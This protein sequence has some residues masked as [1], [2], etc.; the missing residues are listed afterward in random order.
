MVNSAGNRIWFFYLRPDAKWSNGD[1]ITAKDF[2]Y[3]CRRL[4]NPINHLPFAY[5]VTLVGIR[6]A[7][8]II[9]NELPIEKLGV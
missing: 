2:V 9:N 3:S 7:Q 6:N 4:V 8:K 1:L 5:F